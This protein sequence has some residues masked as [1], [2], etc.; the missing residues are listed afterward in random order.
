M[1]NSVYG[2]NPL[3]N[4]LSADEMRMVGHLEVG[5]SL[6]PSPLVNSKHF[7]I[8]NPD[9]SMVYGFVLNPTH[10]LFSYLVPDTF[11]DS[12]VWTYLQPGTL[13]TRLE[14]PFNEGAI[15]SAPEALLE[16]LEEVAWML[17]NNDDACCNGNDGRF[18]RKEYEAE[19]GGFIEETV[20]V[21]HNSN[22]KI[23]LDSSLCGNVTIPDNSEM[24]LRNAKLSYL[25]NDKSKFLTISGKTLFENTDFNADPEAPVAVISGSPE[26]TIRGINQRVT[27]DGMPKLE[28]NIEILDGGVYGR[29]EIT[30]KVRSHG[31]VITDSNDEALR[32]II[33][34]SGSNGVYL[35]EAT[36]TG[37]PF[38]ERNL[39]VNNAN[40]EGAGYYR[41]A[42]NGLLD[43]FGAPFSSVIAEGTF[44][45][46]NDVAGAFLLQ[47]GL[48]DSTIYND[49]IFSP[50]K[51]HRVW[52]SNQIA[53]R[54]NLSLK[55]DVTV[56]ANVS[57]GVNFQSGSY[58]A[59]GDFGPIGI[60]IDEDSSVSGIKKITGPLFMDNSQVSCSSSS[61][62]NI[63]VTPTS[64]GFH[65]FFERSTLTNVNVLSG[66]VHVRDSTFNQGVVSGGS[67]VVFD[68]KLT[69]VQVYNWSCVINRIF[70]NLVLNGFGCEDSAPILGSRVL[71]LARKEKEKFFQALRAF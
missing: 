69:N 62:E 18:L 9:I 31:S 4:I 24:E 61:C 46:S 42:I 32:L 10:S 35:H 23:D 15:R 22:L 34:G 65:S 8:R 57:D 17:A 71:D 14:G 53:Q 26:L 60:R 64:T 29:P 12:F 33:D 47:S 45:G 50:S 70:S 38:L 3:R 43:G 41:G 16:R 67:N 54:S 30:G 52:L 11:H 37:Y 44:E 6:F 66:G 5:Y 59:P 56:M 28:G 20:Q 2:L 48:K 68:S 19:A 49:Y 40:I 21:S 27:I 36:L 1:F 25:P 39:S 13:V 51:F 7:T 58:N 63:N 55:G